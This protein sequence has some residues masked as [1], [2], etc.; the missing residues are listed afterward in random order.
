MTVVAEKVA[1]VE[2]VVET[3]VV[4]VTVWVLW[5]LGVLGVLGVLRVLGVVCVHPETVSVT[6]GASTMILLIY[7][8]CT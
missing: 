8:T 2:S 1:V 5:V 6:A 3:V 4:D 7:S